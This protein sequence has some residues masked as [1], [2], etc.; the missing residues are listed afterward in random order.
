MKF[1]SI[2]DLGVLYLLAWRSQGSFGAYIHLRKAG[3][4]VCAEHASPI[5]DHVGFASLRKKGSLIEILGLATVQMMIMLFMK[6]DQTLRTEISWSLILDSTGPGISKAAFQAFFPGIAREENFLGSWRVGSG[7]LRL[8]DLLG[9][10]T[11]DL[12]AL[13][14]Y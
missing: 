11:I 1:G 8:S 7:L 13:T 5:V 2:H 12:E 14:K 10:R 9:H 6:Y 3:D 4:N